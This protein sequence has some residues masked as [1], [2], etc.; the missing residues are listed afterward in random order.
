VNRTDKA[1]IIER[2]TREMPTY[3]KSFAAIAKF[4]LDNPAEFGVYTIRETAE[5]SG[6][7]TF[8][9]VRMAKSL[10]YDSYDRFRSPFRDA[11]VTNAEASTSTQWIDGMRRSGGLAAFQADASLSAIGDATQSLRQLEPAKVEAVADAMFAAKKVYVL[12]LRASFSLAYYFNYVGEMAMPGV[13]LI[14]R[15]MYSPLDDIN[16]ATD[17]ELLFAITFEP[18]SKDTIAACML[19]KER[20]AKL[21]VLSDSAVPVPSITAD[22]TLVAATLSGHH[23]SSYIGAMAIIDALLSVIMAK[24]GAEVRE[25]I[26]SY[27]SMR[28]RIDAYWT[29]IK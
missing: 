23:F 13:E 27:E 8:T 4:V 1:R 25:R 18:H 15:R 20:G 16:F 21:V 9:L 12:G 2:L 6:V 5:K 26:A 24:G 10:G 29:D 7:S 3:T 14:P 11:L 17:E 28:H 22:Y 19:A